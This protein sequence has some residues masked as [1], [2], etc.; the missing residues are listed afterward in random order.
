MKSNVATIYHGAGK[1]KFPT[2]YAKYSIP[3]SQF[4]HLVIKKFRLRLM[5]KVSA[6]FDN[7]VNTAI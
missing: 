3:R 2:V 7:N 5:F 1:S 4:Q 6:L